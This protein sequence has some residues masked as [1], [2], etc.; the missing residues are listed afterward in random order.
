MNGPADILRRMHRVVL[1]DWPDQDVPNSL[2][3]AGFDVIVYGGPTPD[4]VSRREMVDGRVVSRK[5]GVRPES[6]DLVYAFRPL[7]ELPHIVEES[8]RI[9]ASTIWR[10]S[11]L[12]EAGQRDPSGCAA[13]PDSEQWRQTVAAAGLQY[14][15]D[16][17]I[18]DVAR[19]LSAGDLG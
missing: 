5:I 1:Y 7:A 17:Y 2:A 15:D 8:K 19:R 16:V 4:D 10:Q 6:A 13:D 12:N 18:A 9:G 14:I 11:G 3:L